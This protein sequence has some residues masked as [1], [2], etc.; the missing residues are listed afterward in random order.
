MLYILDALKEGRRQ[1]Y[2]RRP[3][4]FKKER[5]DTVLKGYVCP[6]RM[7]PAIASS[8]DADSI[9]RA[10]RIWE[11]EQVVVIVENRD[12]RY[13][14][15]AAAQHLESMREA[16]CTENDD[17]FE[18]LAKEFQAHYYYVNRNLPTFS[19]SV[20]AI[21]HE[22]VFSELSPLEVVF[23]KKGVVPDILLELQK[24][25]RADLSLIFQSFQALGTHF[26]NLPQFGLALDQLD[27]AVV[28]TEHYTEMDIL[29]TP[30]EE[31][32]PLC[33]PQAVFEAIDQLKAFFLH[34]QE[35]SASEEIRGAIKAQ[36]PLLERLEKEAT[37]SVLEQVRTHNSL[38]KRGLE[39]VETLALKSHHKREGVDRELPGALISRIFIRISRSASKNVHFRSSPTMDGEG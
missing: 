17:A 32:D 28:Q 18:H 25:L 3:D 10:K 35:A 8:E 15:E 34:A 39:M 20:A 7:T 38:W 27:R 5:L 29:A 2:A 33:Q 6:D 14:F 21:I 11:K 12:E 26:K 23:L 16:I 37:Y 1:Y 22:S 13:L 4:Y 24:E 31:I 30:R 19:L 9:T 36:Y